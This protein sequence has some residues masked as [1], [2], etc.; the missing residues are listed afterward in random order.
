MLWSYEDTG[1]KAFAPFHA[2]CDINVYTFGLYGLG[3][4]VMLLS[5][6]SSYHAGMWTLGFL[7]GPWGFW[8]WGS[9]KF[10]Q[11]T[12]GSLFRV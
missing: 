9:S 11:V 1:D 5:S 2:S 6:D 3:K 12:K 8:V 4:G 10:R 7:G